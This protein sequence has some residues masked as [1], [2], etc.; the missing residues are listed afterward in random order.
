MDTGLSM[1]AERAS[2]ISRL[3]T[4][5]LALAYD[6]HTVYF[7]DFIVGLRRRWYVVLAGL[8]VTA[9]LAGATIRFVPITYTSKTSL[10]MLPPQSAIGSKGNPYLNLGGLTQAV[11]VLSARVNAGQSTQELLSAHPGVDTT[12]GPD[13][14]TAGPILL[15]SSTAESPQESTQVRDRLA[16]IVPDAL[17]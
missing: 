2:A 3:A 15:I 14:G 11:D 6:L 5:E 7:G 10:L 16:A 8:L 12:I 1:S 9:G 4:K 13:S 17:V